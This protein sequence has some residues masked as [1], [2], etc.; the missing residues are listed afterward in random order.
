MPGI[1][2]SREELLKRREA[3]LFELGLTHKEYVVKAM[4]DGLEGKE[5]TYS[6]ELDA[7]DFLLG[8][9]QISNE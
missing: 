2:V 5:W 9:D 3:L 4:N 1:E 6:A 7:I 8:E